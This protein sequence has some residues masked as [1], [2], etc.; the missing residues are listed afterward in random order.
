MSPSGIT[1]NMYCSTLNLLRLLMFRSV[2]NQWFHK[3]LWYMIVDIRHDIIY[4]QLRKI[5]FYNKRC[6]LIS[7]LLCLACLP[8]SYIK[9]IFWFMRYILNVDI[10]NSRLSLIQ[11]FTKTWFFFC[12][13]NC[14]QKP[15]FKNLSI[16]YLKVKK[17]FDLK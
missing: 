17:G 4:R 7:R 15:I 1:M 2:T 5:G 13:K 6:V 11:L 8:R 10:H 14:R 3:C 9:S 12:E 16:H